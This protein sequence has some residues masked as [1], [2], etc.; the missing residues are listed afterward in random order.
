MQF[1]CFFFFIPDRLYICRKK[2]IQHSLFLSFLLFFP[3]SFSQFLLLLLFCPLL[4]DQGKVLENALKFLALPPGGEASRQPVADKDAG[5]KKGSAAAAPAPGAAAGGAAGAGSTT[6]SPEMEALM[7]KLAQLLG[8]ILTMN[9]SLE[10]LA[11]V[12]KALEVWLFQGKSAIHRRRALD[13]VSFVLKKAIDMIGEGVLKSSDGRWK[14]VGVQIAA[15]VPRLADVDSSVRQGAMGCLELLLYIDF[16]LQSTSGARGQREPP[17]QLNSLKE[18]GTQITDED[19]NQQVSVIWNFSVALSELVTAVELPVLFDTLLTRAQDSDTETVSASVVVLNGVLQHRG[20]EMAAAVPSL[21]SGLVHNLSLS[22]D[23]KNVNGILRS[24]RTLASHHLKA[25]VDELLAVPLPHPPHV[26]KCVHILAKSKSLLGPFLDQLLET[27]NFSKFIERSTDGKNTEKPAHPPIAATCTLGELF[28]V[29]EAGDLVR[30]KFAVVASSVLLRFGTSLGVNKGEASKFAAATLRK[31][32][33]LRGDNATRELL[34]AEGR[35]DKLSNEELYADVI[36]DVVPP[37][38]REHG[39]K[40]VAMFEFLQQFITGANDRQ[41][42]VAVTVI[43]QL[44]GC[45]GADDSDFIRQLLNVLLARQ[46][47]KSPA[48]KVQAMRGLGN[49]AA[50]G[51]A[52]VNRYSNHVLMALLH[53]VEDAG[54]TVALTSMNSLARIFDVIDQSN[55]TP[56]MVNL[57]LRIRPSFDKPNTGLRLAALSLFATLC[58]FS[59]CEE[60]ARENFADQVHNNLVCVVLHARDDDPGVRAACCRALHEIAR[61]FKVPAIIETVDAMVADSRDYY[62]DF[63]DTFSQQLVV[64]F[65][66][67]VNMH[68]Q[69][70]MDYFKSPWVT[71]KANAATFSCSLLAQ[72]KD[73]SAARVD[74]DV[75][76]KE[77]VNL[78]RDQGAIVRTKVAKGM[79]LLPDF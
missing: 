22:K 30:D 72:S 38:V 44:L 74:P 48:V 45:C 8:T 50:A 41:K 24:F 54:E 76:C 63:L 39:D 59:H 64:H 56:M 16:L 27:V 71:M 14:N 70:C 11:R 10:C 21:V 1:F 13:L 28:E 4:S 58:K 57:T 20:A 55:V 9:S 66:G 5:A 68:V 52:E 60:A 3:F 29:K 15:L 77:L 49:L 26:V 2:F 40:H 33:E 25:V 23:E 35:W 18:F 78:L 61:L 37:L 73:N 34:D 65:T 47:D 36:A 43:A 42:V 7:A 12:L 6:D 17:A 53:G 32:L 62:D 19:V 51:T 69:N 46:T 31:L 79:S 67:N 75:L